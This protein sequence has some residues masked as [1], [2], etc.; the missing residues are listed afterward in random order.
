[1]DFASLGQT[2]FAGLSNGA[3]LANAATA[4]LREEL[5]EAFAQVR[6]DT[7]ETDLNEAGVPAARVRDLG[8]YLRE[9]YSQTPGIGVDG[10]PLA[11]G[12]A[13]RWAD[14]GPPRL[15]PAPKL[16]ADKDML[17]AGPRSATPQPAATG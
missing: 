13:F 11:L 5:A 7:L 14:S 10:E 8:E 16:G 9:I 3:F 15:P 2:A 4:R 1:M 6:A 12:P 17:G